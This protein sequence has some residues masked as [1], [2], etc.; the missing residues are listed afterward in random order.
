[1]TLDASLFDEGR[2]A[3]CPAPFNLA[4]HVLAA[5]FGADRKLAAPLIAQTTILS[6]ATLP[7]WMTVAEWLANR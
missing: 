6:A 5:G 7:I 2:F 1:M 3:P 4:A